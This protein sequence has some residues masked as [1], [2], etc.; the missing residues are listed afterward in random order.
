VALA[1]VKHVSEWTDGRGGNTEYVNPRGLQQHV[2]F[3]KL[4]GEVF[5]APVCVYRLVNE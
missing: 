1:L 4:I 3:I 5:E 2:T